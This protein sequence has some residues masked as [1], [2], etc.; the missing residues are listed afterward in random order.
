MKTNHL[1]MG[2][3]QIADWVC[4]RI[5][6][7]DFIAEGRIPSV[8]ELAEQMEVNPNTISRSYERLQRQELIYTQR[9]MGYFVSE[10]AREQILAQRRKTFFEE[11][12]PELK[13]EMERLRITPEELFLALEHS[14]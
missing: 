12:I 1:T 11:T 9:G 8:R 14:L 3:V 10:G 4:D 2:F 5:L 6:V 7:G 13:T